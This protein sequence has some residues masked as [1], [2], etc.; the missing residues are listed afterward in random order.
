MPAPYDPDEPL[1]LSNQD[2]EILYT[3]VTTAAH[4]E[5]TPYRA[6]FSAYDRVLAERR[7][8]PNQDRVYF[9]FLLRMRG[10]LGV[11]SEDGTQ[12]LYGRFEAALADHGIQLEVD[13]GGGGGVEEITRHFEDLDPEAVDEELGEELGEPPYGTSALPA[14]SRRASFDDTTMHQRTRPWEDDDGKIAPSRR[15]PYAKAGGPRR[16][17]SSSRASDPAS[18]RRRPA[19][20]DARPAM[21]SGFPHRGRLN[22]RI[23]TDDGHQQSRHRRVR[24]L[25]SQ[26]SIKIT[27]TEEIQRPAREPGFYDADDL[28]TLPSRRSSIQGPGP[29]SPHYVPPEMLY[30]PSPTQMLVDA[31]TFL[32]ART[33]FTARR[34]MQRWRDKAIAQQEKHAQMEETANFFNNKKRGDAALESLS[35]AVKERKQQRET[36]MF[37]ERMEDHAQNIRRLNLLAKAFSHW[38]TLTEDAV[39]RTA[40]ARRHVLRFQCFNAW[41]E[42]STVNAL[43]A[44]RFEMKRFFNQ[45]RRRYESVQADNESALA[46]RSENLIQHAYQSCYW[47]FTERRA[48]M[49][50]DDMV[51]KKVFARMIDALLQVTERRAIVHEERE[52]NLKR[53]AFQLLSNRLLTAQSLE[54]AAD[55]FRKQKLLAQAFGSVKTQATLQPLERQF[56]QKVT[57]SRIAEFISFWR[58]RTEQARM[59]TMIDRLRILRNA[60][61][62]WNDNLRCS[63]LVSRIN[64]RIMVE[65]LFKW[66]LAARA[67]LLARVWNARIKKNFFQQWKNKVGDKNARL[68]RAERMFT[69]S[70]ETRVKRI[71]FSRLRSTL[72]AHKQREA[73]ALAI[74]EPRLLDRTC[75]KMVSSHQHVQ[76]LE[77]WGSDAQFFTITTHA[78]KKW[79]ESTRN[80]QRNRR[81][82]AYTTIRRRT[83]MSIARRAFEKWRGKASATDFMDRQAKELHENSILRSATRVFDQLHDRTTSIMEKAQTAEDFRKQKLLARTLALWVARAARFS[84]DEQRAAA[85]LEVHVAAEASVCFKKLNWRLFQVRRQSENGV[86][87]AERNFEKH[88]KN[89]MRHWFERTHQSRRDR[90]IEPAPV[91]EEE[92]QLPPDEQSVEEEPNETG[93]REG[94]DANVARNEDW[95]AFDSSALDIR[96]I[97]L[98][99]DFDPNALNRP[100]LQPRPPPSFSQ[101]RPPEPNPF[102]TTIRNPDLTLGP[103]AGIMA[104]TPLAGYLRTPSKRSTVRAAKA[105]ERLAALSEARPTPA[106]P[107]PLSNTMTAATATATAPSNSASTFAL[108]TNTGST[109]PMAPPS[110]FGSSYY[111]FPATSRA[112]G[113]RPADTPATQKAPPG[114]APPAAATGTTAT[115]AFV[116]DKGDERRGASRNFGASTMLTATPAPPSRQKSAIT[117][118]A[119][120]LTA[121]GYSPNGS[122][123]GGKGGAGPDSGV[124]AKGRRGRGGSGG[125]GGGLGLGLAG[126]GGFEDIAEDETTAVMS[127]GRKGERERESRESSP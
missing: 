35:V 72:E 64:D 50:H 125:F 109:T 32:Y 95:T 105:R 10:A 6:L 60:F 44:R 5:G 94:N 108:N 88:I 38:Y 111:G 71:A 3:I 13:E 113:S 17:R 11:G 89:M 18:S 30:R 82:E 90:G 68:E 23:A 2:V 103:P 15:Y 47:E 86:A 73:Q 123:G 66:S 79:K 31:D 85:F 116:P 114:T 20:R 14:L 74:Y 87:L 49:L 4:L 97:K 91:F 41:H 25:S 65:A 57:Q 77:Q 21:H 52:Q 39:R 27:R 104:S 100:I 76:Q 55:E 75:Q 29:E 110:G 33:L 124:V 59:A 37:F 22:S 84:T 56:S 102:A 43:K 106:P 119:R 61:M 26:G 107:H 40:A 98:N 7:I 70:Q 81:R 80:A 96:D 93:E 62:A 117:P 1:P 53:K 115:T 67:A 58:V 19:S 54:P 46:F 48:A 127:G 36:K 9:R 126:L 42:H 45:W 69:A 28:S 24:S 99:L 16:R 122:S 120:K 8:D 51:K 83:K 118:F 12:T 78:L 63:T 121:Q 101:R 112:A 34:A 92:R